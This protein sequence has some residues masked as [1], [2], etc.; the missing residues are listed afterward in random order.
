MMGFRQA[1]PS[2]HDTPKPTINEHWRLASVAST[3]GD[4]MIERY[5]DI[6]SENTASS[7]WGRISLTAMEELLSRREH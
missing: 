5:S 4:I 6:E 7:C 1:R 2:D 3:S